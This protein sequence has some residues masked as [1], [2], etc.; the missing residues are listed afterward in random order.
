MATSISIEDWLYH[1]GQL[2]S[3]VLNSISTPS[4]PRESMHVWC[5]SQAGATSGTPSVYMAPEQFD[6]R[7]AAAVG[8]PADMWGW[9]ATLVH[10]LAGEAPFAGEAL[11]TISALMHRDWQRPEVPLEALAVPGLEQLLLDCFQLEPAQRPTAQQ[12]LQLLD[13]MLP[14]QVGCWSTPGN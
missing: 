2:Q 8:R 9:A 10:M 11:H 12:A 7:P 6:P 3:I 14:Q 5:A 1:T 13:S 4:T